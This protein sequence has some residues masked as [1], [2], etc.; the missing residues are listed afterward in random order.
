MFLRTKAL[1]SA[2]DNPLSARKK[3]LTEKERLLRLE[4][5]LARME[6]SG[7]RLGKW[8]VELAECLLGVGVAARPKKRR[9]RKDEPEEGFRLDDT[10]LRR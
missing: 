6:K 4:R 10:E 9:K 8:L 1:S 7:A 2:G 3:R 5:K